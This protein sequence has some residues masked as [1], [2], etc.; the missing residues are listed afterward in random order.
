MTSAQ[1][2]AEAVFSR[3]SESDLIIKAA[4]VADYTPVETA[5]EKIKKTD[6]EFQLTLKRTQD[7]LKAVGERKRDDQ[8]LCGFAMETEQLLARARTKLASKHADLIV[9]NDLRESGAGFGI[10]TNRVTVI[11]ASGEETLPLMRKE[12]LA[13]ELLERCLAILKEKREK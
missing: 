9:A 5:S 2:M 13:Y 3:A 10:D 12:D 1:S 6:G 7:I 11:T 8:V 4:A